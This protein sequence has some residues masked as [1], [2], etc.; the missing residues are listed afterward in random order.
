MSLFAEIKRRKVFHVAAAYAV[1]AW[2]LIQVAGEI[3]DP[4]GLPDWFDTATIVLVTLGFPLALIL[5]WVFDWTPHGVVRDAGP[6]ADAAHLKLT[7]PDAGSLAQRKALMAAPTSLA[8]LLAAGPLSTSRVLSLAVRISDALADAHAKSLVHR[9]LQ[10]ANIVISADGAVELA[11]FGRASASGSDAETAYVSPEQARGEAPDFRSDQFSF[12]AVL[13][14]MA[15]GRRAFGKV[16]EADTLAAVIHNDPEPANRI[17]PDVPLPLQW[18]IERCLAKQPNE[19]YPSTRELRDDLASIAERIKAATAVK[20]QA[21]NLPAQRTTL[22]GREREL[23]KIRELVIVEGVRLV[24]L[25]GPGGIGKTRLIVELGRKLVIDFGGRVFFTPLD[26]V[27][28]WELVTSE[29]A[30]TFRVPQMVERTDVATLQS[31]LREHVVAPTLLLIDNF[32]HVLTAAP[33]LTELLA[34]TELLKV[35]VTSRTALR[36]Y[37]EHEFRVTP[38]QISDRSSDPARLADSPAVKLFLD[39]ATSLPR[40]LDRAALD[41]VAEI[42]KLLDGLPLAIELAAARTKVLPLAALLKRAHDPLQLLASGP[43]DSPARQQTLRATLDWSFNL[44]DENHKKLFMRLGVFVGGA[45][46]EAIEAVCNVDEDLGIDLL[47]GVASLVD[48]SLLQQVDAGEAEP[49]YAMLQTMREYAAGRLVDVGQEARTRRAHAAYFLVFAGESSY[50]TTVAQIEAHDARLDRELGNVR[51]ALDW[52]NATR[53]V[54]WGLRLCNS[55]GLYWIR[56]GHGAEGFGRI[57][58]FLEMSDAETELRVWSMC[59]AGDL[60][61]NS[62]RPD[63]ADSYHRTG[64]A[65]ARKLGVLPAMLRG[66]NALAVQA[67]HAAD[68]EGAREQYE[69]AIRIARDGGGSPAIIGGLLSNYADLAMLRGDYDLAQRLHEE[70]A[71]LFR[72]SGDEAALAWSLNHQGDVARK[73]GDTDVARRL[74]DEALSVFRRLGERG[75]V[76][77]CLY[78]LAAI[79]VDTGDCPTALKL[80]REALTLYRELGHRIDMPRVLEAMSRCALKAGAPQRALTLAGGAAAMRKTLSLKAQDATQAELA[81]GLDAARQQMTSAEAAVSWMSGWEM[82]PDRAIAFALG[83]AGTNPTRVTVTPSFGGPSVA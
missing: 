5:S 79:S 30:K 59:W 36:V 14:E 58:S 6:G 45:T 37:G 31:H 15:T 17:N 54:E 35:V 13:Y 67:Q 10:P 28:D 22:I 39:R 75:G 19:R 40:N 76:A 27:H 47:E 32:E 80:H 20:P 48:S 26:Q 62:N 18:A 51:A 3:D 82:P 61:E 74:Y 63:D 66:I 65:L 83:E 53:N 29:I 42:C 56:R 8:E 81:R 71:Q 52:L 2:L 46:L 11:N 78:D 55:L 12:G 41:N 7:A 77:A 38:L 43:R 60:A 16:A 25:T 72:V 21:H 1:V 70:T 57:V 64:L 68:F 9:A 34:S 50:M 24:T 73:R 49:R 44:L 33:K 23:D 69:E 4:L